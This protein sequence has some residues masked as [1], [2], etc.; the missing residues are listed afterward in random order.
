MDKLIEIHKSYSKFMILITGGFL[1]W[2]SN[3]HMNL[4]IEGVEI[5]LKSLLAVSFSSFSFFLF[6]YIFLNFN[7]I[8]EFYFLKKPKPAKYDS[9]VAQFYFIGHLILSFAGMMTFLYLIYNLRILIL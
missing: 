2:L 6:S 3:T 5:D 1:I 7:M 8:F 4:L 9:F